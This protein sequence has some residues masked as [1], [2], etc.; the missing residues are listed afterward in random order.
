M[1]NVSHICPCIR[2]SVFLGCNIT[3]KSHSISNIREDRSTLTTFLTA[4]G[5]SWSDVAD[6]FD[7]VFGKTL[8]NLSTNRTRLASDRRVKNRSLFKNLFGNLL[9]GDYVKDLTV[10]LDVG[11][12]GKRTNILTA[13]E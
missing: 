6:T 13:A 2:P 3:N 8:S 11:T 12:P 5:A 9:N 1:M 4:Q 7:L 10:N